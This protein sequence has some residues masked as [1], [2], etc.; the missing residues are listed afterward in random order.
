MFEY[1]GVHAEIWLREISD[2]FAHPFKVYNFWYHPNSQEL[3]TEDVATSRASHCLLTW[4]DMSFPRGKDWEKRSTLSW[5]L[6]RRTWVSRPCC[7]A[8][9]PKKC[10]CQDIGRIARLRCPACQCKSTQLCEPAWAIVSESAGTRQELSYVEGFLAVGSGQFISD[11]DLG[12]SKMEY[13]L[14]YVSNCGPAANSHMSFS[15]WRQNSLGNPLA[16]C[17]ASTPFCPMAV[18]IITP[19]Q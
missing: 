9:K 12:V 1:G 14:L 2:A 16:K 10:Q 4:F 5:F 18:L 15:S 13:S 17:L 7:I 6:L 8:L 19:W 3:K 11:S